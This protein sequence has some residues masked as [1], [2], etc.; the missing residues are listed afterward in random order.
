MG[1]WGWVHLP[2][3]RPSS[4]HLQKVAVA[5]ADRLDPMVIEVTLVTSVL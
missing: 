3:V 4:G 1:Q 2:L 5:V